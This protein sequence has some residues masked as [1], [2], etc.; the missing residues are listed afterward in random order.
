MFADDIH[1]TPYEYWLVTRYVLKDMA[2]KG[3]L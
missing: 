3:W 2:V 1:P